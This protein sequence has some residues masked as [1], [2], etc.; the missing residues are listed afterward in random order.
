MLSKVL[1]L[2]YVFHTQIEQPAD[3]LIVQA[4]IDDL[5]V[6]SGFDYP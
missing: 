4:V 2:Q 5:T 6:P 1:K 3:V